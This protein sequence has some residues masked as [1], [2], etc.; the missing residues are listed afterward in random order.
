MAA[1]GTI[2]ANTDINSSA[3]VSPDTIMGVGSNGVVSRLG[4]NSYGILN[5]PSGNLVGDSDSQLL[6]NKAV[7]PRLNQVTPGASVTPDRSVAT[8]FDIF[9]YFGMTQALT[10]NAPTGGGGISTVGQRL[11]FIFAD[12][13]TQRTLTWNAAY[14]SAATGGA[15]LPTL[16]TVGKK[17]GVE[18]IGD[19]NGSNWIC[20]RTWTF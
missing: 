5:Q 7:N 19:P 11:V 15:T 8:G 13:G 4:T 3:V 1:L 18:L 6:G 20:L 2:Q 14:V 12:N 9:Y 17:T 10:I 16:T